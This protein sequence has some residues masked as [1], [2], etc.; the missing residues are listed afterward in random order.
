M[1]NHIETKRILSVYEKQ[2][3]LKYNLSEEAFLKHGEKPIEYFTS[4]VDF[5]NLTFKVNE[6]VLIP[7]IETEELVNSAFQL[8]KESKKKEAKVLDLGTGCGAIALALINYL[9][10]ANYLNKHWNFYLIDQSAAA[11]KVARFNYRHLLATLLDKEKV[12]INFSKSNLLDQ[13]SSNFQFDFVLA[14]LPYIPSQ[15]INHLSPSVKNFEPLLA[16][17]GGESGFELIAAAL[18]QLLKKNLLAEDAI[19][20][21]ETDASHDCHFI[22]NNYPDLLNKF[23]FKFIKDQFERQRFL[24]ITI[25]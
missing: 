5:A 23:K 22:K 14:N 16:L 21:F 9:F 19:L 7:R 10:Q 3:L 2:Q 12:K 15:E 17:D 4:W 8:F 13:I 6:Q 24:Q 18:R 20:I 1:S 25:L 11:L